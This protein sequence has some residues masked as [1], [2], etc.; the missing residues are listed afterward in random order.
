MTVKP[1]LKEGEKPKAKISDWVITGKAG[2]EEQL[3]RVDVEAGSVKGYE[4]TDEV[5]VP[6]TNSAVVWHYSEVDTN[7]NG[8]FEFEESMHRTIGTAAIKDDLVFIADFSGLVH[9]LDART[10]KPHWTH[11][12]FAASW[13]S[14]LIAD[15]KVYIGD[16]DGDVTIFEL[17]KELNIIAEVPMGNSVYS[18]PITANGVLYIANK[19]ALFA[20]VEGAKGK[21]YVATSSGKDED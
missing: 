6:N 17:S 9:C 12:M 19:S 4:R 18:T 2:A 11:D 7:G 3:F 1:H 5:E 16:E 15:G 14:P 21:P 10:G 8:K 13:G 20:I